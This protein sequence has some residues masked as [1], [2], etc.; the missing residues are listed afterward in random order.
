M[1]FKK[2]R[3]PGRISWLLLLLR[4][5]EGL[6]VERFNVA[7]PIM[8]LLVRWP[9]SPGDLNWELSAPQLDSHPDT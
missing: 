3:G 7:L 1:S 5:R 8:E 4:L 6:P 2:G 9:T